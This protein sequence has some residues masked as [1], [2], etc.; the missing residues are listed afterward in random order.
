V[1]LPSVELVLLRHADAE[2]HAAT[3]FE[4]NLTA[5]GREHAQVVAE[6][7]D[8]AGLK[9]DRLLSSKAPRAWQ[10]AEAVSAKTGVPVQEAPLY[11]AGLEAL[12]AL[13]ATLEVRR[14]LL[15]GHNPGLSDLA[16]YLAT[17]P[18]GW[19]LGKAAA[20]HLRLRASWNDLS[21]GCGRLVGLHDGD[22]GLHRR[23]M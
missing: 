12:K 1:R 8:A 23:E 2:R 22:V 9:P 7:L 19:S 18:T 5:K 20:A 17:M 14:V 6:R 11:D 16:T 10:T 21:R 3:D 4:R 15:V 13:L